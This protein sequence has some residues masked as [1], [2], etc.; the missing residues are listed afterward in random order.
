MTISYLRVKKDRLNEAFDE[1]LLPN[2]GF[3]ITLFVLRKRENV[4]CTIEVATE[5]LLR[6]SKL[7]NSLV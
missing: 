1:R 4:F 6:L 5:F 3:L 7:T 2:S